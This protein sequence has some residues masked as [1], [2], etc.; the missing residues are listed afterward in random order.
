MLAILGA[1]T[2]RF[3]HDETQLPHV[4]RIGW[5]CENHPDKP[6]DDEMGCTCGAGLPCE[7]NTG[8]ESDI[9]A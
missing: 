2:A 1:R 6:W 7:C 9:N 5:V 3:F 4:P 8:E